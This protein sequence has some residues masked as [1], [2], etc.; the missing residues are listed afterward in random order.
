MGVDRQHHH[1]HQQQLVHCRFRPA[2]GKFCPITVTFRNMRLFWMSLRRMRL[3]KKK[4]T[5][6]FPNTKYLYYRC[7]KFVIETVIKKTLNFTA[8]I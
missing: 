8:N 5:I 3:R 7:I 2:V 4:I 6:H 1:H